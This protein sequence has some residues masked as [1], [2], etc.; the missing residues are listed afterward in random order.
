[1]PLCS[2]TVNPT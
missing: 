1:M 2:Q